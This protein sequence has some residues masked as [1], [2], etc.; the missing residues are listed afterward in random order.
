L[1]D[2]A[3]GGAV[4]V[5]FLGQLLNADTALILPAMMVTRPP[6]ACG[7]HIQSDTPHF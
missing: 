1:E 6:L 4:G 7:D 3:I 5:N 2:Q